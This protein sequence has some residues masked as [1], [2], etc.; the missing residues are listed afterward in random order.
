MTRT[1]I[2]ITEHFCIDGVALSCV[3]YG[4]GHINGT[5]LVTVGKHSGAREAYIL[6]AIN[7]YVFPEPLKVMENIRRVTEYLRSEISDPRRVLQLVPAKDG[8]IAYFDREG[9]CW[10][11]YPFI[12]DSICL[13]ATE[14]EA[15]F[16]QCAYAF[17]EFQKQLI[18]FPVDQ[19]HETLADFH[20]T[21]KRYE[22]FLRA[23]EEDKCGR[24]ASVA[25]E[26]AFVKQYEDFCGVLERAHAAGKLPKRVTH[27]DTKSNNVM[28]D[29]QTHK[30]LC[31]IDLD[32][33]M[34]GYSVTDFGDAIR[35][36]ASTAAEDERDL[37]KVD[38][39]M[40]LF[41]AYTRGFLMGCGGLLTAYEIDL[42]PE[43]AKIMTL[44]CGMRF[45]TDYLQGDVYFKTS[46]EEHNLVRAR[47]QFKLIR[48]MEQH[49]DEMKAFVNEQI[50]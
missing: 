48:C 18:G 13:E 17:G 21:P 20:N 19:L 16:A 4:N 24:A 7:S 2:L 40:S 46:Y 15:D 11:M 31:V 28:L 25:D 44:E 8:G 35:F 10:R 26:I 33:V 36:G 22:S 39:D 6:Q 41:K 9:T 34:P 42:L 27:N 37:S 12:A 29:A 50:K 32:T 14:N 38:F 47:T 43:G 1:P 5:F 49:W 30:P 23:V 3:P 45:L